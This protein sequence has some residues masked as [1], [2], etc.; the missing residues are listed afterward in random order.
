MTKVTIG[1]TV[2]LIV[3]F[4]DFDGNLI[5]PT[6]IV[7]T[8]ENKQ[9]EVLIEI[10]LDAGSKLINSAGL[11]QIGKYY[12]DYTTT[13]VGLLYYYFQGTINGT[14]G[15]RNGSFVVMDIDGTGG[16]R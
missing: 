10:P 12:Y 1:D 3:E 13:E 8:I 15:L 9:R 4:Y 5:D 6:D 14:T 2:R 11:T 16:C 7:I